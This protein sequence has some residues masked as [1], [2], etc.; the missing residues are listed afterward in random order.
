MVRAHVT[1]NNDGVQQ[2]IGESTGQ[3]SREED[4]IY[5]QGPWRTVR[6][7]PGTQSSGV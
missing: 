4:K 1:V 2:R 3:V 7:A 6:S 5:E